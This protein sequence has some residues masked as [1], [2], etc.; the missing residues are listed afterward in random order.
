MLNWLQ[1]DLTEISAQASNLITYK[2]AK[3]ITSE[4][5]GYINRLSN[6]RK[7]THRKYQS[8]RKRRLSIIPDESAVSTD[9]LLNSKISF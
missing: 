7:K 5:K 6:E 4:I 2:V 3:L 9:Y 1:I 8:N